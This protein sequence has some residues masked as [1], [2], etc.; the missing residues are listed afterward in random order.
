LTSG[1]AKE[2]PLLLHHRLLCLL[3]LLLPVIL[4][5]ELA[6]SRQI[7]HKQEIRSQAAWKSTSS[8]IKGQMED[9]R[10]MKGVVRAAQLLPGKKLVGRGTILCAM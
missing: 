10:K 8:Q 6:L 4:P 9:G 1:P 7:V 3:S 2:W 5:P